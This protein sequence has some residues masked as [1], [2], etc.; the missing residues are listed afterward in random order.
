[1]KFSTLAKVILLSLSLV[2]LSVQPA[3]GKTRRSSKARTTAVVKSKSKSKAKSK[4][5]RSKKSRSR[6]KSSKKSISK[7]STRYTYAAP[8]STGVIKGA[9]K[10]ITA[11]L[12]TQEFSYTNKRKNSEVKFEYPIA[13]NK[14]LLDA[15]RIWIR[16]TVNPDFG[17]SLDTPDE[18]MKSAVTSLESGETIKLETK[19][20]Y[21]S[22]RLVTIC[23]DSYIYTS[24]AAHGMPS[25]KT[26]TFLISDGL[27]LSMNMLPPIR[28]LRPLIIDGLKN[29][30]NTTS[31]S[32]LLSSLQIGGDLNN[33]Q[34]PERATPYITEKYLNIPYSAYEIAPYSAGIPVAA[35]PLDRLTAIA[36]EQLKQFLGK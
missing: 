36:G 29:Y 30:F 21:S 12:T 23:T 34:Y 4:K 16:K 32:D 15:M 3:D 17:G 5:S 7:R 35:I 18:L 19:I 11:D 24:G 27:M 28:E 8:K 10:A 33:L 25:R 1:M 6:Y 20:I 14:Q 22:N 13:G 2:M 26:A 31:N 9:V